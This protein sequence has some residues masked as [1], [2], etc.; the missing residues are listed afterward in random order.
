MWF[1]PL[2]FFSVPPYSTS[3]TDSSLDLPYTYSK[4]VELDRVWLRHLP[5]LL[6]FCLQIIVAVFNMKS[7]IQRCKS[8]HPTILPFSLPFYSLFFP[9]GFYHLILLQVYG[10]TDQT[11]PKTLV[12]SVSP[13]LNNS[14]Y[15][16]H[17][18]RTTSI[19][20]I[21]I[22]SLILE[23]VELPTIFWSP[24]WISV[25]P[26]LGTV[27]GMGQSTVDQISEFWN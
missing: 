7:S 21:C 12:T 3:W 19:I 25:L 4:Q 14:L 22:L 11:S 1:L 2:E 13:R 10:G 20:L 18:F 24:N 15:L 8:V 9:S 23:V 5:A 6:T 26:H 17:L 27:N 16:I